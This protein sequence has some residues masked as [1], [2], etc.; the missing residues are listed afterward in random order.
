MLISLWAWAIFFLSQMI[1]DNIYLLPIPQF[2][3]PEP[4]SFWATESIKNFLGVSLLNLSF[5]KRDSYYFES[6]FFFLMLD[7]LKYILFWKQENR[8]KKWFSFFFVF[9]SLIL[10]HLSKNKSMSFFSQIFAHFLFNMR[11]S[12]S[13]EFK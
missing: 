13:K 4:T 5:W 12:G 2:Y 1:N 10:M 9:G 7:I 3:V 8:N 6:I 11:K